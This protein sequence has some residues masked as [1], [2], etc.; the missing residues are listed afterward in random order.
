MTKPNQSQ[1]P[2]E[3]NYQA[4]L[5]S[6]GANNLSKEEQRR[7]VYSGEAT[8]GAIADGVIGAGNMMG[9]NNVA[10]PQAQQGMADKP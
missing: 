1:T 2:A 9:E 8:T 3:A 5:S 10:E 4:A 6:G 7:A